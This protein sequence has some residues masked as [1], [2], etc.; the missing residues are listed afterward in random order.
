MARDACKVEIALIKASFSFLSMMF[1]QD[2]LT[3]LRAKFLAGWQ[4]REQVQQIRS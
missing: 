3:T 1:R 2:L 4:P